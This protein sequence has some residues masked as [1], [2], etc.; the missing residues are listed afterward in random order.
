MQ[1][2]C[3]IILLSWYKY[4]EIYC[5]K[6]EVVSLA[7]QRKKCLDI[8]NP[9]GL[10]LCSMKYLKQSLTFLSL[11]VTKN[12]RSIVLCHCKVT[13]W[14][15]LCSCTLTWGKWS[16]YCSCK[17]FFIPLDYGR[18]TMGQSTLICWNWQHLYAVHLNANFLQNMLTF[19]KI[20]LKMTN[21][22]NN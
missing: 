3:C 16:L 13:F 7:F 22:H 10:I 8:E 15:V 5:T 9:E 1:I 12:E 19:G 4:R 6:K 14:F 11:K 20:P 18:R 21:C 2:L 17:I